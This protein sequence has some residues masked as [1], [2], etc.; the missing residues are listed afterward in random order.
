VDDLLD[1]YQAAI[2]RT[3]VSAGQVYNLGGGPENTLAVWSELGPMLE[4][5]L[6]RPIPVTWDGWRPGDQ[7]I[8]VADIRKAAEELDWCPKVG[9]AEG[10]HR[11]HEWVVA[12]QALFG[13]S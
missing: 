7:Q 2:D 11:L 6:G 9:K 12:N 8:F 5:L 1:A 3:E 4:E 10:V 13:G